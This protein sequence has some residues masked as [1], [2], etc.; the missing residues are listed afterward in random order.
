MYFKDIVGQKE[1]ISNLIQDVKSQRIAHAQMFLGKPGYGTLHLALAFS[2]YI[3][4]ENPSNEDA[5]GKCNSC[6]QIDELQ[7]PDIHFVFPVV[8]SIN[9]TSD[10]HLTEWRKLLKDQP[11]FTEYDLLK[12]IDSAEK[13]PIISVHEA[14]EIIRKLSLMAYQGSYKI[15]ILFAVEKMN[16][17]C[18]NKILKILEEPPKDSLFLLI[19]EDADHVLPTIKSRTKRIHVPKLGK[20][21]V[22]SY[23]KNYLKIDESLAD[24]I[25]AFADGDMCHALEF[26]SEDE[27]ITEFR[28]LFIQLMRCC[29]KKDVLQMLDWAEES[30]SLSKEK[31]K[32]FILYVLHMLRQSMIMNYLGPDH[33]AITK[34]EINFIEKFSPFINGKNIQSFMKS[35]DDAYYYLSRNANSKILFTQLSFQSMRYLHRA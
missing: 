12:K 9:K 32:L 10:M 25:A 14:S 35:M 24:S 19:S 22:S 31:G 8:Q 5:C 16:S 34:E 27:T 7:H 17:D 28:E 21:E 29:Y 11:F 13:N 4:C 1:I 2:R 26:V 23:I 30:S 20:L 3:L 18:S 15:I 6:N 33:V